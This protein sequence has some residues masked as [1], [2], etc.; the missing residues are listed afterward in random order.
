MPDLLFPWEDTKPHLSP[1]ECTNHQTTDLPGW[2]PGEESLTPS[3]WVCFISYNAIKDSLERE[4]HGCWLHLGK[5]W[6]VFSTPRILL[7]FIK[8]FYCVLYSNHFI[9][10]TS[11]VRCSGADRKRKLSYKQQPNYRFF[12][13]IS[14]PNLSDGSLVSGG[15]NKE[16]NERCI[17]RV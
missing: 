7:Y 12:L 15:R 14:P 8:Y 16:N 10:K 2:R 5:L 3:F 9:Q 13:L 11:V 1:G 4:T 17:Y 6:F